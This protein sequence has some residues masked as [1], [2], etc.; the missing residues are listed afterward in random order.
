MQEDGT[1]KLRSV[2]VTLSSGIIGGQSCPDL[3]PIQNAF[4]GTEAKQSVYVVLPKIYHIIEPCLKR[5]LPFC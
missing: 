1:K 4:Y 5:T 3:I 2:D